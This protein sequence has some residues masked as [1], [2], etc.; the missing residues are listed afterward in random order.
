MIGENFQ[1]HVLEAIGLVKSKDDTAFHR[2]VLHLE[3]DPDDRKSVVELMELEGM[4]VSNRDSQTVPEIILVHSYGYCI[5]TSREN[6]SQ[7]NSVN[8]A[9]SSEVVLTPHGVFVLAV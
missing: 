5:A 1:K 7:W 2:S 6:V 3:M 4:Y 8:V 9:N